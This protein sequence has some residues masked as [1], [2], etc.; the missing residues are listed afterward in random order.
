M[1]SSLYKISKVLSYL[2]G[3]DLLGVIDIL[4]K[5]KN[6]KEGNLKYVISLKDIEN[7]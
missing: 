7:T 3:K 1:D 5:D 2:I 6:K 4:R